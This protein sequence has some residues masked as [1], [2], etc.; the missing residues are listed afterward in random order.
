MRVWPSG[1]KAIG[2]LN[3]LAVTRLR[4]TSIPYVGESCETTLQA[5]NSKPVSELIGSNSEKRSE[6]TFRAGSNPATLVLLKSG[7]EMKIKIKL[8]DRKTAKTPGAQE[9]LRRVCK[10]INIQFNTSETLAVMEDK[11][12]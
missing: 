5:V 3:L 9:V 7:N 6:T 12:R 8:K 2:E 4:L 11:C 10:I 1:Q